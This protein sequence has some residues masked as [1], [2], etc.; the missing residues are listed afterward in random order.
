M[1]SSGSFKT[2]ELAFVCKVIDD[3]YPEPF[4]Y[5]VSYE[6]VKIDLE[7]DIECK[8]YGGNEYVYSIKRKILSHGIQALWK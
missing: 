6:D 7:D 8:E 1:F 4:Y 5:A 2:N 3:S